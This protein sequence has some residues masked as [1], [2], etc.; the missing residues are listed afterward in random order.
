MITSAQRLLLLIAVLVSV[1]ACATMER[2]TRQRIEVVSEPSGALVET[3]SCGVEKR[4]DLTTPAV[5]W[6]SRRADN[7]TIHLSLE[8][9]LPAK[10][11]LHREFDPADDVVVYAEIH[12]PDSLASAL[13]FWGTLLLGGL[14]VDSATGAAW[15]LEPD[16]VLVHLDRDW[17]HPSQDPGSPSR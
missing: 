10:V 1:S 7:C 6:V 8:G 11:R 3:A 17:D 16:V 5:L 2:G 13:T 15:V 14:A 12:T 9:Y 4:G